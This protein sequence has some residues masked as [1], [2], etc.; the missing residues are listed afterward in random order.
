MI[1]SEWKNAESGRRGKYYVLTRRGRQHLEKESADWR[2]LSK[3]I[4]AL[5]GRV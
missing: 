5:L 4:T 2:R 3:A 1:R